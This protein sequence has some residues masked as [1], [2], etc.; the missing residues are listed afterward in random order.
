MLTC[1]SIV[2]AKQ[3]SINQ[4]TA[5]WVKREQIFNL[6]MNALPIHL[7]LVLNVANWTVCTCM[8]LHMQ[9]LQSVLVFLVVSY[10]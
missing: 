9:T 7:L 8:M 10:S 2:L 5:N 3:I 1:K 6:V 4:P